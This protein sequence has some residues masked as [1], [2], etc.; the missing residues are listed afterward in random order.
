MNK[1]RSLCGGLVVVAAISGRPC[2]VSGVQAVLDVACAEHH[3]G[4][5]L[6]YKC[7]IVFVP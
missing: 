4:F 3:S 7:D 5:F 1:M 6:V 2:S